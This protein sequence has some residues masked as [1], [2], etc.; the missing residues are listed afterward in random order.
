MNF[1]DFSLPDKILKNNVSIIT[2]KDYIIQLLSGL[3]YMHDMRIMHRDLK[4]ANILID[5]NDKLKICDFGMARKF[6]TE[7]YENDNIY[8]HE[9]CTIITRPIEILLGKKKYGPEIDVWSCGC[10][11]GFILKKSELF[12]SDPDDVSEVNTIFSIFQKLG[13]P[14]HPESELSSLEHFDIKF[15]KFKKE[16]FKNLEKNFPKETEIIY[17]LLEY[18]T[19]KR[20]TAKQALIE[21]SKI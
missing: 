5:I 12:F 9:V 18:E 2:K 7:N 13:T 10:V 14:K 15:P 11:I 4:P 16:G 8:S 19:S 17:K 1:I 20:I 21:F 6:D 3:N